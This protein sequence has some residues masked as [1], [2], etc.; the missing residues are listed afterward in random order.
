MNVASSAVNQLLTS[1]DQ[2]SLYGQASSATESVDPSEIPPTAELSGDADPAMT[3]S[4]AE[5]LS[6]ARRNREESAY[7]SQMCQSPECNGRV[8]RVGHRTLGTAG[9][10][11]TGCQ[12]FTE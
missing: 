11:I 10:A 8:S 3:D 4:T 9:S 5:T 1:P 2:T 6:R 7:W 12:Q